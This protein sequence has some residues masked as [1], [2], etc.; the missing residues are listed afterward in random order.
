MATVNISDRFLNNKKRYSEGVVMTV[1]AVLNVGGGRANLAPTYLKVADDMVA[2]IVEADTIVQKAYLIV[3]EAFPATAVLGADIGGTAIFAGA[4]LTTPG[5]A[6][7]AT[8]D[9][10]TTAKAAITAAVTGAGL[11]AGNDITTGKF[12]I[13]LATVHPSLNNGQYAS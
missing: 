5:I 12:R 4:D 2:D 9:L 8:V 11:T 1:P 13:V 6:A 7:S 10:Y 3:D